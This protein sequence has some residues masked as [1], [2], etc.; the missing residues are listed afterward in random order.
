MLRSFGLSLLVPTISIRRCPTGSNA[1]HLGGKLVYYRVPA[2]RVDTRRDRPRRRTGLANS[3]SRRARSR[4]G[5][6]ANSHR[7]ARHLC[8]DSMAEFRR[9]ARAVTRGGPDQASGGRHEKD[10]SRRIDDRRHFVLGWS[11]EAK[12]EA[13]LADAQRVQHELSTVD[14]GVDERAE[15]KRN[16]PRRDAP[17]S[18]RCPRST[19]TTNST[20]SRSPRTSRTC[21]PASVN[22]RRPRPSSPAIAAEIEHTEHAI[23]RCRGRTPRR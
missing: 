2:R 8:V 5:S 4:T 17:R 6:N 12:I 3:T 18:P 19:A 16:G 20:G 7:R 15:A 14:G 10:D 21:R 11:N 22:S 1:H 23:T 9:Q 13:L